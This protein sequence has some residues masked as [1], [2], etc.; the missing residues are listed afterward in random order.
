MA[1]IVTTQA[2]SFNNI[3]GKTGKTIISQ[4]QGNNQRFWLVGCFHGFANSCGQ[5][6]ENS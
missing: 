5:N 2:N 4:F 3:D 6:T 1:I